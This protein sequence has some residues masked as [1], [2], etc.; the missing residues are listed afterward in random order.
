MTFLFRPNHNT[1]LFAILNFI[2]ILIIIISAN[3]NIVL[4]KLLAVLLSISV[5]PDSAKFHP[6]DDILKGFGN[7][8]RAYFVLGTILNLLWQKLCNSATFNYCKWPKL[9]I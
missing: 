1:P 2:L 5:W 9:N 6:F 4:T 8:I 3:N 7:S